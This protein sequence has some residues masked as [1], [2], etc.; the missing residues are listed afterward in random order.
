MVYKGAYPDYTS[1]SDVNLVDGLP[2]LTYLS[3]LGV[4]CGVC[5][6]GDVVGGEEGLFL[7]EVEAV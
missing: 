5:V 2:S 1:L 7:L 4:P 3:C 6:G